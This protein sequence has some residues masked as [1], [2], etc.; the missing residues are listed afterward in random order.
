MRHARTLIVLLAIVLGHPL[1]QPAAVA[2]SQDTDSLREALERANDRIEKLESTVAAMKNGDRDT[3]LDEQ[4]AEAVRELVR[5]VIADADQ[6]QRLHDGASVGYDNG[7]F[8]QSAD[9][10]NLL[11]IRGFLAIRHIFNSREDVDDAQMSGF[12]IA[13][14]RFGFMGHVI[15]PSW[16]YKIWTGDKSNGDNILLDAFIQKTFD[17]AVAVT[18]GQFKVPFWR[19]YLVSEVNLPFVERSLL[20]YAT[21]G[22][23]T[24]GVKANYRNDAVHLVA[25]INDGRSAINTTFGEATSD[26]AATGRVEWK[27]YGPWGQYKTYDAFRG[28]KPALIVGAA[29]HFEEGENDTDRPDMWQWTADGVLQGDGWNLVAAVVGCETSSSTL[30]DFTGFL[31]QG[32]YFV[33]QR[34]ELLARYEYANS[35]LSSVED[36]SIATVGASLFFERFNARL[37][38]DVGYAFNPVDDR[39][40][41]SSAGYLVDT[42]GEAGQ[43]VIRSQLQLLF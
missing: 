11:K 17:N 22:G 15:D 10:N 42:G 14:T 41:Q 34:V 21:A 24:Q 38:S 43:I 20:S 6:R 39:W 26:F 19:E 28:S 18:A 23:Y 1:W 31:L 37:T 5:E 36:L 13:R 32:G 2:Q 4:R 27:L 12:E 25:S 35:D 7:F 3:W 29:A 16:K 8:I 30:D 9:G 40:D 33:T